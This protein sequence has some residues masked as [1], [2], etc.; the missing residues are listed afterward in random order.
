MVTGV[1]NGLGS[2]AL[3]L[4]L[5]VAPSATSLAQVMLQ[6]VPPAQVASTRE[7]GQV[8]LEAIDGGGPPA[9]LSERAGGLLERKDLVRGKQVPRGNFMNHVDMGSIIT[10]IECWY[11]VMV[12]SHPT[13][14]PAERARSTGRRRLR[15]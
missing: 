6:P 8:V 12:A 4:T 11:Q 1:R 7:H 9:P 15:K 5:A 14:G 10:C 3:A 13:Q 2:L